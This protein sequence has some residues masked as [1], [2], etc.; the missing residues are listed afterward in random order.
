[1]IHYNNYLLYNNYLD[2]LDINK[3]PRK[4]KIAYRFYSTTHRG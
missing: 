4:K 2:T 3:S 1:M